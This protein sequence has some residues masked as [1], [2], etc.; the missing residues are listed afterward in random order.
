MR[1]MVLTAKQI[2]QPTALESALLP[3]YLRKHC[4]W[5]DFRNGRPL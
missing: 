4:F 3:R 5:P 1:G 2:R